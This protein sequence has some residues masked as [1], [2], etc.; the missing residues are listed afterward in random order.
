MFCSWQ[1]QDELN[2]SV[3]GPKEPGE[4]TR[5]RIKEAKRVMQK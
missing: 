4:G 3:V 1:Q 5:G 2:E